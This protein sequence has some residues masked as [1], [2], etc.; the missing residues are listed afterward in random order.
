MIPL[1]SLVIQMTQGV[2]T[3]IVWDDGCFGGS[4]NCTSYNVFN[5]C[6]VQLGT[7]SESNN[8]VA[9]CPALPVAN[10][11]LCDP[12]IYISFIGSDSN[13]NYFDSAGYYIIII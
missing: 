2:V 13:G 4:A 9:L 8:Y 11:T 7:Y 12:K 3:D 10:T 6:S 5:K 1:Y